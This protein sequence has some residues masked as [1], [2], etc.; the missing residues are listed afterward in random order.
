MSQLG[1]LLYI[2]PLVIMR[3]NDSLV[4]IIIGLASVMRL[5]DSHM[6]LHDSH[7][8][9]Y[10]RHVRLRDSHVRLYDSH[11][12]LR[13]SQ[14]WLR[15]SYKQMYDSHMQLR[16]SH[17]RLHD[18][19]LRLSDSHLRLCDSHMPTISLGSHQN[20]GLHTGACA[21]VVL[22]TYLLTYS[23]AVARQSYAAERQSFGALRESHAAERQSHAA[24]R[25]SYAVARQS[26]ICDCA[27]VILM[28]LRNS[29]ML[30]RNNRGPASS[31]S[32]TAVQPLCNRG[33]PQPRSRP[34]AQL[35]GARG[36]SSPLWPKNGGHT[37]IPDS[38]SFFVGVGGRG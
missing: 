27:T 20:I 36:G 31:S 28:Q 22:L 7:K 4:Y 10:D 23:Y 17:E 25:Q 24:E 26:C 15:D 14:M 32:A 38:M 16:D 34:G 37:I 8:R 3:I 12:R 29:H 33:P 2:R 5:R 18:S 6:W 9:M 1:H 19:H 21:N 30:L 11:M 35:G 13:D